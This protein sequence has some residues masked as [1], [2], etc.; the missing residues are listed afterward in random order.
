MNRSITYSAVAGLTLVALL[1]GVINFHLPTLGIA[2]E[3]VYAQAPQLALA[4]ANDVY[5]P[6]INRRSPLTTT[7][8]VESTRITNAYGLNQM[9]AAGTT[10][11]RRNALLWADAEPSEGTFNW[12]ALASLDNELANASARGIQVLLIV[13][14][15]PA[16]AQMY[17]GYSCGPVKADKLA[18]FAEFMYQVV[19]RY[20][21][22]PYNVRYWQIWNEPD[23]DYTTVNPDSVYGCWGK[24]GDPYYG[25]EYYGDMLAQVYPRLKEGNPQAQLVVGGLLMACNADFVTCSFPG[26]RFLEGILHRHGANDG[27]NF[28]NYVAFHGYDDYY[29]LGRYGNGGWHT[30][31]DTTGP[32]IAAKANYIR[33]VLGQYGA[34]NKGLIASEIALR[35]GPSES[36]PSCSDTSPDSDFSKTKAYYLAEAYAVS[37]S[38]GIHTTI[39]YNMTGGW[40]NT[41]LV[42]QDLTQLLPAYDAFE[43]ARNTLLDSKLLRAIT[44]YRSFDPIS[45]KD[46]GLIGFEF[47]RGDLRIWMLWS[48]DGSPHTVTLPGIPIQ[49]LDAVGNSLVVNGTSLTVDIKPVYLEWYR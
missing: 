1:A 8:G 2:G 32:V 14:D 22:A 37:V 30:N 15:T 17:A 46:K 10:W 28:F 48:L 23:V 20:S 39:W 7:F 25:G 35:C 45:N 40:R 38:Q 24:S 21:A 34:S 27:K 19:K 26:S 36:D 41:G 13:R 49:A 43:T 18:A 9:S 11:I 31:W 12:S 44:E 29:G 42:S 3:A 47:D 6:L 5:L 33:A 4:E 16:W